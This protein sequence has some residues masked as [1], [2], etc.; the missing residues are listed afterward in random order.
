MGIREDAGNVLGYAYK[1]YKQGKMLSSEDFKNE[2]KW[3]DERARNAVRYLNDEEMI[4]TR[5]VFGGSWL[6]AKLNPAGID[7]IESESE[8]KNNFGITINLG[9]LEFN[10]TKQE[11]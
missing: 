2:S 11:S 9:V 7:V 10:W 6:I 4:E 5:F 3:P 8:F 1:L